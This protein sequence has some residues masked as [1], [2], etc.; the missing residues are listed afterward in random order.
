MI[1]AVGCVLSLNATWS[2]FKS[3][4]REKKQKPES[5]FSRVE[6]QKS[7]HIQQLVDGTPHLWSEAVQWS[8]TSC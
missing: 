5:V 7:Q 3:W 6:Q 1:N 4:L 8:E 2:E